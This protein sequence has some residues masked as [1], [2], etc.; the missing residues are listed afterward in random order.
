MNTTT[1]ANDALSDIQYRNEL[2]DEIDALRFE[3]VVWANVETHYT[4]VRAKGGMC[5]Y[6]RS[7]VLVFGKGEY[8]ALRRIEHAAATAGKD[9]GDYLFPPL[10]NAS[11]VEFAKKAQKDIIEA[12]A[13]FQ[14][15]IQTIN[16]KYGGK[17]P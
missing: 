7:S 6:I 5:D 3:L 17:L 11:R 2:T 8:R 1:I 13:Y 4:D 9:Y 12:I 16:D 15:R 10:D 14:Q